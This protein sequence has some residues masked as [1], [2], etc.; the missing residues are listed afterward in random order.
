MRP[1]LRSCIPACFGLFSL[2]CLAS[3]PDTRAM[4]AS[5]PIEKPTYVA[6]GPYEATDVIEV[7]FRSA[8]VTRLRDGLW[9]SRR[10]GALGALA[11]FAPGQG[12]IERVEPLFALD[13]SERA[14]FEGRSDMPALHQWFRLHLRAGEDLVA[15]VNR[16]NALDD[17]E[18]AYPA[19][20]PV[21]MSAGLSEADAPTMS[22]PPAS[23]DL[24][25]RQIYALS[26]AQG[27]IDAV[28]ARSVAG[29]DGTGVRVADIEYSWNWQHED[30]KKLAVEGTWI[31]QGSQITD[32]FNDNDHG[33]A[34][35]G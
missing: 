8:D 14:A 34:V 20:R 30:L 25:G 33:T 24:E 22:P 13:A 9:H 1:I 27:G 4:A 7:K 29:G 17:V 3:S 5:S 2:S 12:I 16:L 32:P 31:R 6:L 23:P 18:I 21:P 35:L 28:Y 15:A 11:A 26:A 19:P 10:R